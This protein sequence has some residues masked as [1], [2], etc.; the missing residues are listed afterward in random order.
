M[1][2]RVFPPADIHFFA[3]LIVQEL[4]KASR[5]FT[6]SWLRY[7]FQQPFRPPYITYQY[8]N[9]LGLQYVILC[10]LECYTIAPLYYQ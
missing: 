3:T 7:L 10:Y 4:R 9:A 5:A 1:Q 6:T 2:V 8:C